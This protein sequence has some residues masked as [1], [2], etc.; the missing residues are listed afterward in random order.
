LFKILEILSILVDAFIKIKENVHIFA[1]FSYIRED[2]NIARYYPD[3]L[4][5]INRIVFVVETKAQK[6]IDNKNVQHKR[7][8][9]ENALKRINELAAEDRMGCEWKYVLLGEDRFYT[10]KNNGI[11]LEEILS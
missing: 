10:M 11:S 1:Y 4:V 3:F 8:A 5:K 2:G 6:D 9:V 7:K